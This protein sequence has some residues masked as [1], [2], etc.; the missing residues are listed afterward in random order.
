MTEKIVEKFLTHPHNL[1]MGAGK[2]SRRWRVSE[3]TIVE[4]RIKAR[5]ILA[6]DTIAESGRYIAQLEDKLVQKVNREKGTLESTAI[7][8]FEAKTDEEL[9][10]L[11]KIDLTKYKIVTYWSKLRGSGKFTSSV[12]CALRRVETDPGMAVEVLK[13][14]VL[15]SI[16]SEKGIEF[17]PK[18]DVSGNGKALI[19]ITADEH[20]AAANL[21]DDLYNIPWDKTEYIMRKIRI[22]EE[23]EKFKALHGGFDDLINITL[24]DSLD[25]WN[26]G[27]TRSG[28]PG[29]AHVLPQNMN[30]K[31]AVETYIRTNN[32]YWDEIMRR[33]VANQHYKYDVVNS[34]HGGNGLDYIASLGVEIY[35]NAKHPSV[36]IQYIHKLLG[37]FEYGPHTVMLSHGKDESYRK[38][39][40]PLNLN[41]ETE[42]F[43][44]QYMDINKLSSDNHNLFLKGDLHQWNWNGGKFFDYI[45]VGS[46]YGSSGWVQANF[47]LTKPSFVIG[48]L[49]R[50]SKDFNLKP[51]YL[52]TPL[53]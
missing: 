40:M 38:K 44:K 7:C 22:I 41:P 43:I 30:N 11:H 47:G 19:I 48:W 1:R 39:P 2:L 45:N 23:V 26:G 51:V 32:F 6:Q 5:E 42:L 53:P 36:N 31:E 14:L 20:V 52:E 34:N 28:E 33:E 12:F 15:A 27:T 35:L 50:E 29:H 13:E 25:G 24:G 49:D 21:Q 46:L 18:K 9:A 8:N 4:A 3:E 17:H 10:I 16:R 37:H